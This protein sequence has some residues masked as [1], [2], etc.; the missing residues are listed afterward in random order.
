MLDYKKILAAEVQ[1]AIDKEHA[2]LVLETDTGR[3]FRSFAADNGFDVP[4]V[5]VVN[6]HEPVYLRPNDVK[7]IDLWS[8]QARLTLPTL[9]KNWV[10]KIYAPLGV[11]PSLVGDDGEPLDFI[12]DSM[13]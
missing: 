12:L 3:M 10:I 6:D 2:F 11:P 13:F 7:M 1:E 4:I 9:V 5:V 8:N